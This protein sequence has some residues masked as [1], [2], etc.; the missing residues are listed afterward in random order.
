[1]STT[2]AAAPYQPVRVSRL[3]G[4]VTRGPRPGVCADCWH[5]SGLVRDHCDLFRR[6]THTA[7][8]DAAACGP[9][10][11]RWESR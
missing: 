4:A 6:T 10:A 8:L 7:K 11:R 5:S 9:E 2:R 3:T 1:M